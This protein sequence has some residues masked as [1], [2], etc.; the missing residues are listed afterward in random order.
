ML[1][2]YFSNK[3]HSFQSGQQCVAWY[4]PH[5]LQ[6][7]SIN[8]YS[9]CIKS[10]NKILYTVGGFAC[11]CSFKWPH[12]EKSKE[13]GQVT[14][15]AIQWAFHETS[16]LVYIKANWISMYMGSKRISPWLQE[17]TVHTEDSLTCKT[18]IISS[19]NVFIQ[20]ISSMALLQ[21]FAELHP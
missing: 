21:L 10:H 11:T 12:R 5:M 15:E 18:R 2:I 4:L 3:H 13:W 9:I 1:A 19:K 7:V 8:S 14:K 16:S 6:H 17:I 20:C